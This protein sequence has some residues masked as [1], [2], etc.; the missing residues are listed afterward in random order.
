MHTAANC[1]HIY[2]MICGYFVENRALSKEVECNANL[3]FFAKGFTP[4][5]LSI[6]IF[7]IQHTANPIDFIFIKSVLLF[8]FLVGQLHK[9]IY[10]ILNNS[11]S[12]FICSPHFEELQSTANQLQILHYL[13][14]YCKVALDLRLIARFALD[15][16]SATLFCNR[17]EC[18]W[19][20]IANLQLNARVALDFGELRLNATFLQRPIRFVELHEAAV[21]TKH[22][23]V[24]KTS[25]W[26]IAHCWHIL[27]IFLLRSCH[28]CKLSCQFLTR[29]GK[30]VITICNEAWLMNY[31]NV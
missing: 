28:R 9:G 14:I 8:E 10:F 29:L 24:L 12:S 27:G 6:Q 2:T 11:P 17:I 22:C 20:L 16:C 3:Q 13:Q 18:N 21:W 4:R 23:V 30:G 1:C 7:F 31:T 19:R 5:C 26:W 15:I 25:Q